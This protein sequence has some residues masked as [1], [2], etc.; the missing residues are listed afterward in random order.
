MPVQW[1]H[2]VIGKSITCK[3]MGFGP[4]V[5]GVVLCSIFFEEEIYIFVTAYLLL[6]SSFAISIVTQRSSGV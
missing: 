5:C 4:C 2:A 1:N 6:F 3:I